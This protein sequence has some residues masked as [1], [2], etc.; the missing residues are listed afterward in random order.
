MRDFQE[1]STVMWKG[2]TDHGHAFYIAK[3]H[4]GSGGWKFFAFL[5]NRPFGEVDGG[6]TTLDGAKT[7]LLAADA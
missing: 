3:R 2:H 6:Y 1:V 5:Q 7:A 4:T